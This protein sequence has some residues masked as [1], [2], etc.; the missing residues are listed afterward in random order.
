MR[1][2]ALAGA[3][4]GLLSAFVMIVGPAAASG[5]EG[6][7][8][9]TA[10]P[11]SD[12]VA[13]DVCGTTFGDKDHRSFPKPFTQGTTKVRSGPSTG[14]GVV[15]QVDTHNKADY[16]CW[17]TGSDGRTWTYMR[18]KETAYGWVRDDLLKDHGSNKLC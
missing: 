2:H 4:V 1:K 14:C 9:T 6:E 13:T 7:T 3:G 12:V 16:H 17:D 18:V 15:T 5:A 11:R 8:S 10:P